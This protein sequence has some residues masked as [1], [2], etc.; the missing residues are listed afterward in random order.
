MYP[1]SAKSL[2]SVRSMHKRNKSLKRLT[3]GNQAI[4]NLSP[5]DVRNEDVRII[6]GLERLPPTAPQR[7]K[8]D[9]PAGFDREGPGRVRAG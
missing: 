1:A 2:F 9:G 6:L 7:I 5:Q 4:V 3:P 8:R